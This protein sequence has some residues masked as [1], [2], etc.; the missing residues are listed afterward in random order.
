MK[1]KTVKASVYLS[2]EVYEDAKDLA[3]IDGLSWPEYVMKLLQADRTQ[4]ADKL[5][6]F[7]SLRENS[8]A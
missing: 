1:T 3:R 2:P 7:R 4:R 8:N 6:V 5:K